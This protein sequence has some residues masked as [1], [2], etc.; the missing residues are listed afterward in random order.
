[1]LRQP[2]PFQ[3]LERTAHC[4]G[5]LLARRSRLP[6]ELALDRVVAGET[7]LRQRSDH[8]GKV[9]MTLAGTRKVP[10]A[11]TPD[12]VLEMD[13]GDVRGDRRDVVDSG[14]APVELTI[15]RVVV[16]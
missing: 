2:E 13:I 14:D 5:H 8:P 10:N 11:W 6:P 7:G 1:M 9:D 16:D 3:V 4:R 15:R 12:L